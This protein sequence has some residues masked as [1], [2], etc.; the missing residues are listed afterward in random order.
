MAH[1]L[2]QNLHPSRFNIELL[3]LAVAFSVLATV[4]LLLSL[5]EARIL[6]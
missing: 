5:R 4:V 6:N 2:K 1:S 3:R